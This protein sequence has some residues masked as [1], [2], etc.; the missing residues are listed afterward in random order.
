M[1]HGPRTRLIGSDRR[2]ASRVLAGHEAPGR[3]LDNRGTSVPRVLGAYSTIVTDATTILSPVTSPVIVAKMP[4][5]CSSS[6]FKSSFSVS[7][8]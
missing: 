6:A 3:A 2:E 8:A 5:N 1:C 4:A 7:N